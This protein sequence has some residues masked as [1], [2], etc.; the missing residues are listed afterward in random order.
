MRRHVR[1]AEGRKGINGSWLMVGVWYRLLPENTGND[2][3]EVVL[4]ERDIRISAIPGT[5]FYNYVFLY[6]N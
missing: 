3:G 1:A 5:L 2:S 4:E 6:I